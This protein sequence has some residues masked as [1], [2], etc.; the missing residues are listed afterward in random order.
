MLS[1]TPG[2]PR[3]MGLPAMLHWY[4]CPGKPKVLC[5]LPGQVGGEPGCFSPP[6]LRLWVV[7]VG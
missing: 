4:L 1:A 6:V 7:T 3:V 5:W 2:S